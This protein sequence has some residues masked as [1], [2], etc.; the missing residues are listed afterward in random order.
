[1]SNWN[2]LDLFIL[3]NIG[4]SWTPAR[5]CWLLGDAEIRTLIFA[6]WNIYFTDVT[7]ASVAEPITTEGL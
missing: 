1:M 3:Q 7:G 2:E 4:H 5:G 6:A